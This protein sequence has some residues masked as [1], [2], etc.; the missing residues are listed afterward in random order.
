MQWAVQNVG[1]VL[2]Q[3]LV[4]RALGH[5][6]GRDEKTRLN[7]PYQSWGQAVTVVF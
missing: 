3:E 4:G 2:W 5:W 6:G 7:G 1:V